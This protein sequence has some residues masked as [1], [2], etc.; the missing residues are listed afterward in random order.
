MEIENSYWSEDLNKLQNLQKSLIFLQNAKRNLQ[1]ARKLFG[2]NISVLDKEIYSMCFKNIDRIIHV[3]NGE[4]N[5]L[6]Y[7][8]EYD[9]NKTKSQNEEFSRIVKKIRKAVG[10]LEELEKIEKKLDDCEPFDCNLT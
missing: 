4:I 8:I 5:P 6:K 10:K 7:K 9:N 2:N 3:A 1:D